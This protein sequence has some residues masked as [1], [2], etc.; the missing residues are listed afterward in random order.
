MNDESLNNSPTVYQTEPANNIQLIMEPEPEPEPEPK[1]GPQLVEFLYNLP[2]ENTHWGRFY[3]SY[4]TQTQGQLQK[5]ILRNKNEFHE[6]REPKILKGHYHKMQWV[7]H[8]F[9]MTEYD[10]TKQCY[11]TP[12]VLLFNEKHTGCQKHTNKMLALNKIAYEVFH[13]YWKRNSK[14][15]AE[16]RAFYESRKKELEE[17]QRTARLLHA[18]EEVECPHCKA[19]IARSNLSRHLKTNKACKTLQNQTPK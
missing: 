1:P 3:K 19:K 16:V 8:I 14:E 17:K 9:Y 13:A 2:Y 11:K 12:D 7:K 18:N 5:A 6:T 10:E 15:H 4:K